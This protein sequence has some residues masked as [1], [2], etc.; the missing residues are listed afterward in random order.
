MSKKEFNLTNII[1][2]IIDTHNLIP[3]VNFIGP[4][5]EVVMYI[6]FGSILTF[7]SNY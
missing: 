6:F 5:A 3:L 1:L 7:Y 2:N 4:K